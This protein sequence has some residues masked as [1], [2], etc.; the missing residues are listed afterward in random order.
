MAVN[1]WICYMA[2][3]VASGFAISFEILQNLFQIN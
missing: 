3:L 1:I 2:G